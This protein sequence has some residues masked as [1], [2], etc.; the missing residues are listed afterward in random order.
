MQRRRRLASLASRDHRVQFG[1]VALPF[2]DG[3]KGRVYPFPIANLG[4]GQNPKSKGFEATSPCL[5]ASHGPGQ[6]ATRHGGR[7]LLRGVQTQHSNRRR[8]DVLTDNGGGAYD[9]QLTGISSRR[10]IAKRLSSVEQRNH[11]GAVPRLIAPPKQ[12]SVRPW[13]EKT[14]DSSQLR[15]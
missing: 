14:L 2:R 12:P 3:L 8:L 4:C 10:V 6:F 9:Q 7:S 1:E 15:A 13:A 11:H 5:S